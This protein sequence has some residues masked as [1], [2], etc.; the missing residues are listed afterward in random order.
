MRVL[1]RSWHKGLTFYFF[2]A[3]QGTLSDYIYLHVYVCIGCYHKIENIRIRNMWVLKSSDV[4]G[5]YVGSIMVN[6]WI[7]G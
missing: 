6:G 4:N 3:I 1:W 5:K 7:I 2:Q